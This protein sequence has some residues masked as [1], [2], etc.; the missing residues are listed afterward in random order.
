[1]RFA[2]PRAVGDALYG[3][4]ARSL[5]RAFSAPGGYDTGTSA[6]AVRAVATGSFGGRERAP[7][8]RDSA[9][10]GA[11]LARGHWSE[12]GG[13]RAPHS[14]RIDDTSPATLRAAEVPSRVPPEDT[15]SA[16]ARR[17]M[18]ESKGA[19]PTETSGAGNPLAF[20][21]SVPSP[22]EP[23]P[24]L[25]WSNLN[26][27]TQLKQTYLLCEGPDGIYLLDQH[28]A[29]ERVT[30]TRLR[31]QYRSR[32]V[33]AQSLLFPVT[34][35]VSAAESELIEARAPEIAEVGLDVRVR[36]PEIV[37]VHAIPKLLSRATPERVLRDLLTEVS[38]K[39]ERAFSDAVDLA[40]ATM[41]CHGS[42]R[43]GDALTPAEVKALL[44][45][46]DEADFAGHCPHGRPVV[47]FLGWT[48][49]ERKVGRR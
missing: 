24:H 48:E 22:I 31:H 5:A 43:A 47:T 32:S 40:L 34:V 46:L 27:I 44:Q 6:E 16:D 20:F 12:S 42:V 29:A 15:Q 21:D 28:A 30:F 41:A 18:V 7:A 33:P 1:V 26:F 37:S 9:E 13:A 23:K 39:G 10:R 35:E 19:Y 17:S 4:L 14:V 8:E 3:I 38:R 11:A 25:R 49:L 2:D 36:S 45:A